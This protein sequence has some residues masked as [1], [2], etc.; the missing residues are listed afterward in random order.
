MHILLSA[1]VWIA[2]AAGPGGLWLVRDWAPQPQ[3][4]SAVLPPIDQML[5]WG[6]GVI[7]V[8]GVIGVLYCAGKM[9][10][11][12]GGRADLGAEGVGG[13]LWTF[14]GIFLML[15]ATSVVTLLIEQAPGG[16]EPEII[17]PVWTPP[18]EPPGN[19]EPQ[20]V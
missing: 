10:A 8:I 6:R 13:L 17:R 15:I 9:V 1:S 18:E 7:A 3:L 16:G 2:E 5:A 11:A 19:D 14:M 4:P 12:K 20:N